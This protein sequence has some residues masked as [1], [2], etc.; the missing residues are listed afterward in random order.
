MPRKHPLPSV[1]DKFGRLTVVGEPFYKDHWRVPVRC[2]CG[3]ERLPS[4][5]NL[6]AGARSC[7]PCARSLHYTLP[8]G[9]KRSVDRIGERH[10]RLVIV[11]LTGRAGHLRA[12]CAC[13]CGAE[14][15]AFLN[16]ILQGFTASCGCLKR[17]V[18]HT[19]PRTH[20]LSRASEYGI[21]QGMRARCEDS[22]LDA[23]DR[24]GGRGITVCARWS[25]SFESF[26][27]DMGMRP[28]PGHSIDRIDNDGNYEPGNCRWATKTE[29]ARNSSHVVRIVVDGVERPAVE[30][31]QPLGISRACFHAR[32]SNGW[33]PVVAATTPTSRAVSDAQRAAMSASKRARD[34]VAANTAISEA[35]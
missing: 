9:Q 31:Y 16:N 29:Q 7:M 24:Y 18:A 2:E 19:A 17:E 14:H 4:H 5:S 33:D 10:G 35:V 1:G 6:I 25:E 30:I 13:D 34:A 21:W 11:E 23:W 3:R 15:T 32:V 12:R 20:G 26:I 27:A 28:T 8:A 22:T